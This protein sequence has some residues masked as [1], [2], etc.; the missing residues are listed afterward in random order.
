MKDA[1]RSICAEVH[2]PTPPDRDDGFTP[3]T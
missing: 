3:G 1:L 2:A